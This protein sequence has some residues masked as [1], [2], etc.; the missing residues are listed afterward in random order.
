MED[1]NLDFSLP[2][3]KKR[4]KKAPKFLDNAD[5]D[6]ENGKSI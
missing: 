5:G 4:K 2:S 6:A 1:S 3:K